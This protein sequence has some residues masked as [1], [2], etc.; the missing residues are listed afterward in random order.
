M[1][2]AVWDVKDPEEALSVL[3]ITLENLKNANS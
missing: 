3:K 2:T 1:E